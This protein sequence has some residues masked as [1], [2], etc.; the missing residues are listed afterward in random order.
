MQEQLSDR[1]SSLM[2][3]AAH[4]CQFNSGITRIKLTLK[5]QQMK[6]ICVPESAQTF[7][8]EFAANIAGQKRVKML[9]SACLTFISVLCF[10]YLHL[11]AWELNRQMCWFCYSSLF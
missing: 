1:V 7:R 10:A 6:R 4:F 3:D 2:S 11:F 9:L 8:I 5:E